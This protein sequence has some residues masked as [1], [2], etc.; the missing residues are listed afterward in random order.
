MLFKGPGDL[1]ACPF[2]WGISTPSDALFIGPTRVRPPNGISTSS[3]V[4]CSAHERDQETD[5]QTDRQT[6][7]LC[8]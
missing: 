1:Q 6:T 4:F 5:I 8:L 7:L 2:L 3:A